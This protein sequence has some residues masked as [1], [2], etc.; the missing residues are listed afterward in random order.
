[1][2]KYEEALKNLSCDVSKLCKEMGWEMDSKD[3][4]IMKEL[5]KEKSDLETKLAEKDKAIEN[6][7]T[8]YESVMQT[9]HNDKEEIKRLREQIA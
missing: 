9:C 7:Q 5:I 1:M 8:M 2:S 4:E 3:I 6:W